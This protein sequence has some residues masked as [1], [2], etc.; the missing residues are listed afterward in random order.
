MSKL[1]SERGWQSLSYDPFDEEGGGEALGKFSLVTAFE[2]FEHVPDP[3]GLMSAL[4][5]FLEPDGMVMFSTLISDGHLAPGRPLQWWYAS[6]R[7]GHISLYTRDS[8]F[9]LGH[10]EG[11]SFGSFSNNLHAYWRVAPAWARHVLPS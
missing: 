11:L 9:Y 7:N 5:G 10:G 1:L 3:R 6:P 4:E 2:V 8:L